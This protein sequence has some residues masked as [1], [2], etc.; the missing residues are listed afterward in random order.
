VLFLHG[1]RETYL[2][3]HAGPPVKIK[4]PAQIR[5][6][7]SQW[8]A[9]GNYPRGG[10][11]RSILKW[12]LHMSEQRLDSLGQTIVGFPDDAG[13]SR[14]AE[15][16]LQSDLPDGYREL[17]EAAEIGQAVAEAVNVKSKAHRRA[18]LRKRDL[19]DL[20]D[21]RTAVNDLA[22]EIDAITYAD[23]SYSKHW[24]HSPEANAVD[25]QRHVR[26]QMIRE[27][28]AKLKLV[29]DSVDGNPVTFPIDRSS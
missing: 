22:G 20:S 19:H 2:I 13:T 4:N 16:P 17:V 29:M 5:A 3:R 11:R 15:Q 8:L 26:L 21:L 9:F 7:L 28:L 23:D 14:I 18:K 27:K 25:Q 10:D 24:G 1:G 6:R 12:G